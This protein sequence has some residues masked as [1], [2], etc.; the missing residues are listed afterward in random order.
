MTTEEYAPVNITLTGL[1]IDGPQP[2]SFT[3]LGGPSNGTLSGTAPNLTYV[4]APDYAGA[5]TFTFQ[6]NDGITAS[7]P[8]TVS[9]TVNPV[10]STAF[11]FRGVGTH[12]PVVENADE[13]SG[14][15]PRVVTPPA[16]LQAGDLYVIVAAYRGTA[17]LSLAGTGG[18]TWTAE[19]NAQANGQT[20]RVFWCQ[21]NGVW[22]GLPSVTNTT[23]T[24]TLSVY[25]FAVAMAAGTEPAIDVAFASG[26]HSGGTVTVPTFTTTTAGA[27][28]LVGWVSNDNNAW[29]APPAGWSSPGGQTQWR[30]R[31]GSDNTIS[32]AY[33]IKPSMGATGSI[34][35]TQTGNG[36]DNGLYFRLAFKAVVTVPP[37]NVPADLTDLQATAAGGRVMLT[38]TDTAT[39][40][41]GVSIERCTGDGCTNFMP[42]AAVG[43][44]VTSYPDTTVAASTTYRYQVQAYNVLGS[45]ANYSNI[46]DATTPAPPPTPF[47]F[48]GVGTHF[49]VV[50][51]T[52]EGSGPGPRAVTPPASLQLGDLYVIVAAYRGTATLGLAQTGGQAWTAEANAQA[53][54]QTVRV[55]WSRFNGSWTANPSVTNTTGTSTLTVYSFAVDVAVGA[56]PEIDV[57]FASGSHSGDTVTVPS[58]T[59][60]TDGALALVGWVSGDN[61]AWSAPPAGWSTP[62]GQLQWRNANGSDNSIGLAYQVKATIGATGSIA[63]GQTSTAPDSGLYFRLAW[64]QVM[65]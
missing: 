35:R 49:P 55:F 19:A 25:S 43:P 10:G 4:P 17:T 48:R 45:S 58:F 11:S 12:F 65:D 20:A 14:P 37:I 62:G 30:N 61:N 39:N 5:D 28:A 51:N 33:Q 16:S 1:N 46:A 31:A 36:P 47:T 13:G 22:T 8:A 29:S 21:F 9:I 23:G 38:W 57:A 7:N 60:T 6:V 34:A 56:H 53:N 44:N 27:L 2:L 42:I 3:V 26:S 32:L 41:A 15:G 50:E 63:R 64:K 54:G 40:E 18:Q 59:T 24:S 52:D